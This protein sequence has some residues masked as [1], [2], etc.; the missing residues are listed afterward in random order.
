MGSTS[1]ITNENGEIESK[2]EYKPFGSKFSSSGLFDRFKFTGKEFDE[3]LQQYYFLARNYLSDA[4]RFT[5]IDPVLS[6]VRSPYVYANNNPFKYVDPTGM[7]G[8]II[9]YRTKLRSIDY[10]NDIL[11]WFETETDYSNQLTR[12]VLITD[13][14][15]RGEVSDTYG[16]PP[17]MR[18]NKKLLAHYLNLLTSY[19]DEHPGAI[20]ITYATPVV[21]KHKLFEKW[22]VDRI[23]T[24]QPFYDADYFAFLTI[25]DLSETSSIRIEAALFKEMGN[26]LYIDGLVGTIYDMEPDFT[27]PVAEAKFEVEGSLRGIRLLDERYGSKRDR[28]IRK[29]YLQVRG[30]ME[31]E[32]ERWTEEYERQKTLAFAESA[33]HIAFH[34]SLISF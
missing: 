24:T 12:N 32:L 11:T 10:I 9:D 19:K 23:K 29:R 2:E 20:A 27:T 17:N 16:F 21:K 14:K 25:I 7:A 4:G 6:A 8:E 30:E 28:N 34:A 33:S 18:I 3:D 13:L 31:D 15:S 1:L 26:W 5:G 22:I